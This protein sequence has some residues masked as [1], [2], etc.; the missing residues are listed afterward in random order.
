MSGF[1]AGLRE[2]FDYIELTGHSSVTSVLLSL[3]HFTVNVRRSRGEN[4]DRHSSF[5]QVVLQT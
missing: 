4:V 1:R 3:T 2:G 5:L